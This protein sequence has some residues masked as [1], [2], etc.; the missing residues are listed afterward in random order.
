[1]LSQPAEPLRN[2]DGATH[3][4]PATRP[5]V[6]VC[7]VNWNCRKLLKACLRSLTP[8]L[9]GVRLEVIVVD[10]A[11]TDGA[12]EMVARASRALSCSAIPT[13]LASPAPTIRPHV[14]RRAATSSFSITIPS[15]RPAHC[16][17]WSNTL[18]RIRKSVFSDPVCATG[19]AH[20]DFMPP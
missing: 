5:V 14:W 18:M 1:M 20:P 7:I 3:R 6:S 4:L 8:K 11:S 17:V 9:Q 2:P 10:N 12:A 13:T 16:A 15:S 19:A